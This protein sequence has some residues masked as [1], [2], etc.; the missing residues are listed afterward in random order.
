MM[1]SEDGSNDKQ[2]I[3]EQCF[4]Q[5]FWIDKYEVTQAQFQ[6]FGGKQAISPIFSGND[7]PVERI[8]WFEARNFCELRDAQ[9]PTEARW[10]Y[11][12]RGPENWIYPWGNI[13]NTSNAVWNRGLSQ[14]TASTGSI[15]TGISW[16]GALDMGGNVW[17]WTSSMY[18]SYP[19][20]A[21]DGREADIDSGNDI[22]RVLRGGSW[23]SGGSGLL[24]ASYRHWG[25]STGW[26]DDIGFR[27]ARSYE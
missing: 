12:A 8:T 27:C 4:D 23:N 18:E 24:R 16:V 10:E 7:R 9:L 5:P 1:G 25:F 13:W 2:P 17:E 21:E 14:G 19:Y 22:S 15:P 26:D 6:G 3:H 11:A 20:D